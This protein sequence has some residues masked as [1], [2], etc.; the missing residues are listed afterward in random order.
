MFQVAPPHM[1]P[2]KPGIKPARQFIDAFDAIDGNDRFNL[3]QHRIMGAAVQVG[4]LRHQYDIRTEAAGVRHTHHVLDA[5]VLGFARTGD[6]ASVAGAF[7]GHN[8]DGPAPQAAVVL[9]FDAGKEAV[10]IEIHA[11]NSGRQAHGCG[12]LNEGMK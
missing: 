3:S 12:L 4:L 5:H 2:A 11:P 8:A 6:D 1:P 7:K 10:E 9:L